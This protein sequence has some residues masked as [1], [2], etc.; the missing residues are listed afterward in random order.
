MC[1]EDTEPSVIQ[2]QVFP[3]SGSQPSAVYSCNN[4]RGKLSM[5]H[6]FCCPRVSCHKPSSVSQCGS[7]ARGIQALAG[8]NLSMGFFLS[9]QALKI[10]LCSFVAFILKYLSLWLLGLICFPEIHEFI[11]NNESW[12]QD[13]VVAAASSCWGCV[14]C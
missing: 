1:S 10:N 9:E 7:L 4:I 2:E 13:L 6:L 5:L 14:S 8:R 3:S 12:E 11:G